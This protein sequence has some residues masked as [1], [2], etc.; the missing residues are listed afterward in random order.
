MLENQSNYNC[1]VT[2]DTGDEYLLYANWLHNNQLDNWNGW[3]CDAGVTRILIDK[4][5]NV[6]SGECLNDFLGNALTDFTIKDTNICKRL[7]CTGCTD[8]LLTQKKAL[9]K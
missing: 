1:K 9:L 8:D 6:H 7:T 4:H 5:L 3:Q 2:T